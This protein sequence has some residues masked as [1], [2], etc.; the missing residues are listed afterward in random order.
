MHFQVR[1]RAEDWLN[2]AG[3][4]LDFDRLLFTQIDCLTTI[5]KK[6]DSI[7]RPVIQETTDYFIDVWVW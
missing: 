3:K 1:L 2:R 7:S 6:T 5:S 4:G